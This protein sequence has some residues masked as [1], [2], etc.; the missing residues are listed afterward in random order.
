MITISFFLTANIFINKNQ[1]SAQDEQRL[2]KRGYKTEASCINGTPI[3]ISKQTPSNR[4]QLLISFLERHSPN[5]FQK[6][7]TANDGNYNH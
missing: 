6:N 4:G 1:V 7:V 3:K 5:F 2:V